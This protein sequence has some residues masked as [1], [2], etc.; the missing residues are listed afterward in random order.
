MDELS[1]N[2]YENQI[3]A[4]LGHNGAGKTT[5]INMLT[6]LFPPDTD[7]GDST[8]YGAG[9]L[10]NMG[11][12]RKTLGVCPQHD[13]LFDQ[14]TCKEHIVFFSLL[15]GNTKIWTHAANEA[16]QLLDHFHLHER[17]NYVGSELSGGMKRKLSTAIAICG[18][19]KFIVLDEPTAGMDP[20]ARRELWDLLKVSAFLPF[21]LSTSLPLCLSPC[22][23]L[24]PLVAGW[25]LPFL[26]HYTLHT[27]AACICRHSLL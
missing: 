9:V 23:P 8:I 7:S 22:L 25:S 2:L 24:S 16:K 10:N 15:K 17:S 3:F 18:G 1:F 26:S 21:Y 19:S 6:G 27:L 11:D 14:L 5:T 12:V 20:L 4:L 13:V